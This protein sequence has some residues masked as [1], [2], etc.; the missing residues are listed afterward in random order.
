MDLK[1]YS[2]Q[3]GR[4]F[5]RELARALRAHEPDVSRWVAG[6][7]PVP[8]RRAS[9]IEAFTRGAVTRQDMF[10][11]NWQ[12]IWPELVPAPTPPSPVAQGTEQSSEVQ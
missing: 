4:G 12:E 7:R 1:Q 6:K 3:Y 11:S 8:T 2:D 5:V 10:P 9:A